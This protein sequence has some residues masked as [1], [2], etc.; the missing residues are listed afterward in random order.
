MPRPKVLYRCETC[1]FETNKKSTY[2]SHINRKYKCEPMTNEDKNVNVNEQNNKINEQNNKIN[3]QNN[4]INEQKNKY[5]CIKCNKSYSCKQSLERHS[6]VCTSVHSLQCP[7]CK[8]EFAYQQLKY[9]HMK[10]VKCEPVV[11]QN[12]QNQTINN[13]CNVTNNNTINNNYHIHLNAFGSENIDYLLEANVLQDLINSGN[14]IRTIIEQIHFNNEHP[15]NWNMCVRN[16]RS[17]HAEIYDGNRFVVK[18]KLD[19][20]HKVITNTLDIV[21]SRVD[22]LEV[23]HR[24]FKMIKERYTQLQKY[25]ESKDLLRK[26]QLMIDYG[27]TLTSNRDYEALR[28]DTERMSYNNRHLIT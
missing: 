2:Q 22:D 27:Q 19:V 14:T 7:I 20:L 9:Y 28:D 26:N 6:K 15:E 17:K 8:K 12:I 24:K 11:S 5:E 3:E 4:K 23:E 1:G 18:D 10:N 16:L 13:N 25:I 21:T